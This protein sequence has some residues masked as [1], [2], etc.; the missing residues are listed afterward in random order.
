MGITYKLVLGCGINV[1][2]TM[3]NVTK[4]L[5][6]VLSINLLFFFGQYSMGQ[7]NPDGT[8]FYN[9]NGSI[10][11]E[12][13]VNRCDGEYFLV[14][15]DY[16]AE[17]LPQGESGVSP[18][19]GNIFTDIFNTGRNWLLDTSGV[20]YLINIVGAPVSF[21]SA[22]GL[23]D[24]FVWGIGALWYGLTFFLIIGWLLGREV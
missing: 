22:I 12:F 24:A 7:I 5:L 21:L 10:L 3:T 13:D 4:A 18:E 14:D 15:S 9:C 20:R 2:V 23:P 11:S 19:T 8:Q 17:N 16:A 1:E 6:I